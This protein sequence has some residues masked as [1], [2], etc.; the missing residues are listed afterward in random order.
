[1]VFLNFSDNTSLD[2][3]SLQGFARLMDLPALQA[4]VKTQNVNVKERLAKRGY[5]TM[6]NLFL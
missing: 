2:S 3:F 6:N 1:M 5:D 4:V